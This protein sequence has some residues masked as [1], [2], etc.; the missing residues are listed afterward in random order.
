MDHARL[1]DVLRLAVKAGKPPIIGALQQ[2][3]KLVLPPGDRDVVDKL[4]LKGQF[5]IATAR[6]TD[7]DIQHKVNELSHRSR[8][9]S[10][11]DSGRQNAVSNFKGRF[12][13]GNGTLALPLLTFDTR[14]RG[15]SPS[16]VVPT[17]G[18]DAGF[19]RHAFD[20]R[21]NLRDADRIQARPP[22][23]DRST[24][25]EGGRRQRHPHQD[26]RQAR[27]PVVRLGQEP[28]V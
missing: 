6:F 27:E 11:P 3:T 10:S 5:V 7:L 25:Q 13:L 14:G 1:E 17:A 19:Q 15:G 22:E 24:V 8:G 16:R 12:R 28:R 9:E 20:G 26:C 18:R 4:R 2:T 23:G 21:E